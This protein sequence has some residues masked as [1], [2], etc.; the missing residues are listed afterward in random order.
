MTE[1]VISNSDCWNK[2]LDLFLLGLCA[3][4]MSRIKKLLAKLMFGKELRLPKYFA[5][6]I[7]A[8]VTARMIEFADLPALR[9]GLIKEKVATGY[10][11]ELK[12]GKMVMV[13][14][15]VRKKKGIANK[16]SVRL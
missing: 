8:T 11:N 3:Q 16:N 6:K 5:V 15:G 7:L 12:E 9:Q 13:L 1:T 10:K 14:N 2:S 4:T